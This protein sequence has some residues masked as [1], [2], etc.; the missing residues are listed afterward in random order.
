MAKGKATAESFLKKLAINDA[1]SSPAVLPSESKG[2]AKPIAGRA[3]LKHFGGYVNRETMEKV[4]VLRA[5]LD[6]DN[7]ELI[8]HA[9]N[10]LYQRET[11]ARKFGDR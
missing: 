5:R 8:V 9:I 7:S 3:G 2:S 10:E 4:A 1:E 6:L 11:A